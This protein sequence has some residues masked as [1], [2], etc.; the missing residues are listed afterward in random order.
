M[1]KD[2]SE[3]ENATEN[4][5]DFGVRFATSDLFR[6][7]FA[8]GMALVEETAGYLD[9]LG[10]E[11][12]K[13]LNRQVALAYATESMRLTTRLMQ[14]ASWLLLQRAVANGEMPLKEATAS[15]AS[16]PLKPPTKPNLRQNFDELPEKIRD[17]IARAD[18]I[19]ARI[20]R[21]DMMLGSGAKMANA[22][23]NPISEQ[24]MRLNA[25]FG[26]G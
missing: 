20:Y 1:I 10:R 5:V 8:Q 19:H 16:I 13:K 6:Q 4:A 7:V 21:L 9:G 24:M 3:T 14:I 17:L 12:S 26:A 15:A 25:E 11:D 2:S 22:S 18:H 23:N